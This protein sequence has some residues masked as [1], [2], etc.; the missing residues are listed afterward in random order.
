[1]PTRPC[2]TRRSTPDSRAIPRASLGCCPQTAACRTPGGCSPPACAYWLLDRSDSTFG[3]KGKLRRRSRDKVPPQGQITGGNDAKDERAIR[4]G[5][6]D[7]GFDGD[8][9][10]GRDCR[11]RADSQLDGAG[12][13]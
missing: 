5:G 3:G 9:A 11:A 1:M 4:R 2:P 7:N 6:G 12:F 8:D 13:G 10:G